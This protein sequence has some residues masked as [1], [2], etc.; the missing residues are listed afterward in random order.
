MNI[1]NEVVLTRRYLSSY[2]SL[3]GDIA[4]RTNNGT[5]MFSTCENYGR[6]INQ[7]YYTMRFAYSPKFKHEVLTVTDVPSRYGIRIHPGNRGYDFEGCIGI[8]L[9]NPTLELPEQIY[10]SRASTQIF[11]AMFL[12]ETD[13][14]LQI[15]DIEK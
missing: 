4:V 15:I 2:E 9:Y 1:V 13:Y 7:G 5:F 12:Q 8:G 3:I 10:Y 14:D 6:K 11:E